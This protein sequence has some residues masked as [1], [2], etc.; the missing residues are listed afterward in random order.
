M[1]ARIW[2]R[3]RQLALKEGRSE[4]EREDGCSYISSYKDTNPI[5]EGSILMKPS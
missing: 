4:R 3:E 1:I 5:R 2:E